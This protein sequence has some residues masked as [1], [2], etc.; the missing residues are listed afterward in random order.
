MER[1]SGRIRSRAPPTTSLGWT[2]P[3]TKTGRHREGRFVESPASAAKAQTTD[4]V[5]RAEA[6]GEVVLTRP[7]RPPRR[8][9]RC[10]TLRGL[11]GGRT[12]ATASPARSP[13]STPAICSWWAR[14]SPAPVWSLACDGPRTAKPAMVAVR[15]AGLADAEAL[16]PLLCALGYPVEPAAVAARSSA[17]SRCTGARCCTC[18]RRS[19]AS[20]PS[21]SPEGRRG[22]GVGALLVQEAAALA[23]AEGCAAL[24][25]TT[26]THRR[27]AQAFYAAQGF[28][29]NSVRFV[30]A[31]DGG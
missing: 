20:A 14:I 24:E 8:A 4:S 1:A 17:R 2:M 22:R 11:S 13:R 25:V 7:G 26:G 28:V 19:R 23:R 21:W 15:R 3:R 31:L 12:S 5:R 10:W 6:G 9:G 16:A 27:A 29:P 30:R 18:W